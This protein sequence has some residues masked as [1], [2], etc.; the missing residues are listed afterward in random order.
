MLLFGGN[1]ESTCVA[2]KNLKYNPV[3][4]K[5]KIDDQTKSNKKSKSLMSV[6]ISS[7]IYKLQVQVLTLGSVYIVKYYTQ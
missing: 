7:F 6:K 4:R 3:Q 2:F 1:I 5:L